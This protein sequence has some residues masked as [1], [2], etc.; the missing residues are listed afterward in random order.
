VGGTAVEADDTDKDKH[1]TYLKHGTI[2]GDS[3][4]LATYDSGVLAEDNPLDLNLEALKAVQQRQVESRDEFMPERHGTHSRSRT[5]EQD[6]SSG[7]NFHFDF[8]FFCLCG[9]AGGAVLLVG[10]LIANPVVLIVGACILGAGVVGMG[11]NHFF[12]TASH[13]ASESLGHTTLSN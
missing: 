2:G 9:A 4:I 13:D 10:A 8:N 3:V 1:L 5:R 7:A 11:Y 6:F 12:S